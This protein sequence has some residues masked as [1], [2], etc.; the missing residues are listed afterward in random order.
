M[1]HRGSGYSYQVLGVERLNVQEVLTTYL[2]G[3]IVAPILVFGP[4]I[5]AIRENWE[6][7][8]LAESWY[9][10]YVIFS[11]VWFVA[12]FVAI[13]IRLEKRYHPPKH[14]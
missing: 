13:Y 4:L 12:A 9:T 7:L 8:N 2:A 14:K 3:W 11:I 5:L 10:P 1:P 6:A